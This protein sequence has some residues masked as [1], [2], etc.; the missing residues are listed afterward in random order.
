MTRATPVEGMIGYIP[1]LREDSV[2]AAYHGVP[3]PQVPTDELQAAI[4]VSI[5]PPI[6]R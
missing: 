4:A 2:N 6:P 1:R 5:A 3:L